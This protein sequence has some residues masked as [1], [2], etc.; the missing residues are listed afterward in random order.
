VTRPMRCPMTVPVARAPT[1]SRAIR[2][3]RCEFSTKGGADPQPR[4]SI[5]LSSPKTVTV[6]TDPGTLYRITAVYDGITGPP[7]LLGRITPVTD[8]E[9]HRRSGQLATPL[10]SY[11]PWTV[12]AQAAVASS[13]GA[14]C[15]RRDV[16][17][18]RG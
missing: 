15:S 9:P 17:C 7:K 13:S 10:E 1:R 6:V 4:G 2:S 18:P 16:G 14:T 3:Y 5:G 12:L 11:K 8:P